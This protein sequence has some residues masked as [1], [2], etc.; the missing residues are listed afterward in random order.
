VDG[1]RVR[2]GRYGSGMRWRARYVDPEGRERSQTF[3]RRVDA[4]RFVATITADV[5]RGTYVDPDAG[6]VRSG[7]HRWRP[8]PPDAVCARARCSGS[9]SRT[10]TSC[11][12][13][14]TSSSRSGSSTAASGS[15]LRRTAR[16]ATCRYR[17]TSPG[18]CPTISSAS[19]SARAGSS[20]TQGSTTRSTGRTSTG[21]SGSPPSRSPASS[22]PARTACTRSGTSTRPC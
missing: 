5:L 11:A 8:W 1:Q 21:T 17:I 15:R 22:R 14:S 7:T 18:R 13:A 16:P 10:S 2:T 20:S 4:E 6:K 19:P 3:A 9:A 12:G